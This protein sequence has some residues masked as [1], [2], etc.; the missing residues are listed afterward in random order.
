M[1]TA[2]VARGN[3]TLAALQGPNTFGGEAAKRFIELYPGLFSGEIIYYD[4]AED[5]LGF[6]DGR[7]DASCAPQQMTLTGYHP[8]I[9]AYIASPAS[10][11]FVIAEA[12]HAYRCSLLVKP[13]T[14]IE[15][16]ERVLGH[17]GSITQS[18]AWLEK[19]ASHSK[20]II[21][22]TSSMDAAK[23]VV[24]G[25]GTIASVGTSG[26]AEEFGLEQLVKDIDGGSIGSYWA[27]SPKPIFSQTPVRVVVAGRFHDD[28]RLTSVISALGGAGYALETIFTS[29][30]GTRLFEYDYVMR[31]RGT[32]K[33]SAAEA[34]VA[35]VPG[36]RLAGAFDV[37]E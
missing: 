9:Q 6:N 36:A 34:A 30:S 19:H 25:D 31:F 14:K 22:D 2:T 4:T 1:T 21:V 12:T 8:G 20:I 23:Q 24:D 3:L 29:P 28:G 18:R 33:L 37:K 7:A 35:G 17:T 26:M 15:K 13:G 10:K 16:I 11:L 32:G 27:L 5:A